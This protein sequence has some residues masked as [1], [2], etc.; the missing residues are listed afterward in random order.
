MRYDVLLPP[1]NAVS[2]AKI[3]RGGPGYRVF[4][5]AYQTKSLT[6]LESRREVSSVTYL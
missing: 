5:A 4:G 3:A 1:D 6:A 2:V